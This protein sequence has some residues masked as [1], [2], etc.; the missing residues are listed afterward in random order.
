MS[1]RGYEPHRRQVEL[2]RGRREPRK[3]ALGTL[4]GEGYTFDE[5]IGML[6]GVTLESVVIT[7]R[8]YSVLKTRGADPLEF[9]LMFHIGAL[10][11][12]AVDPVPWDKFTR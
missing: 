12:G 6:S 11:E 5:A 2:G 4:L 1:R 8:M 7:K 10:L 9:P 3:T